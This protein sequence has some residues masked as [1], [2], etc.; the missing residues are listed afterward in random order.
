MLWTRTEEE[1]RGM[2]FNIFQHAAFYQSYQAR[3]KNENN[4]LQQLIRGLANCLIFIHGKGVVHGK[5]QASDV[6]I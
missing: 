6:D 4:V 2:E 5:L 3:S 1:H